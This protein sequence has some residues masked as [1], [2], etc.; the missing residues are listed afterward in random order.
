MAWPEEFGGGGASVWEQTV[1]REEMW[2]HHEPRGAQYMGVNWVGPIIMRHGTA[3]Q[4]RKHLPPDRPRRGDLVPGL[5]R[6]R[7]RLRPRV[8]ADHR[9]ARRRRLAGHRPEDLDVLRHHGA[10]VLPAGPHVEQGEKKQQGLTIFLVPMD[11]PAI[12]VRPIRCMMGPH[13]LNEVFFD[14]LR[15]TEADVLGTVDEGWSIVQDVLSFERVGIARYARCERLLA[16]A[17]TVL[18]DRWDDLPAELR[19]TLGPHAD[20]L[21]PGPAAGL[22]GRRH[23]RAA[24]GSHPATPRRTGSRSPSSTRTAPRC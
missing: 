24:G 13:H 20:A 8:A 5:H 6:A 9:A 19:G 7:G 18:G 3:E 23:C 11:D 21:P 12:Q 22:P 1:V 2:A 14:D 10:V 17:P 4:Q 15:V 16:A